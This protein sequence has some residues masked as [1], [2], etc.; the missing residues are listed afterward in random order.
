[1]VDMRDTAVLDKEGDQWTANRLRPNEELETY[2]VNDLLREI[3]DLKIVGVRPKPVGLSERLEALTISRE[4]LLSL[5]TRGYYLT[6]TGQMMSNEGELQ[7]STDEGI[8]YTLRF[9][10]ILHGTGE[11]I[12]AGAETTADQA[13]GPAENRYL[14]VSAVFDPA[15]VTAPPKPANTAFEGKEESA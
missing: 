11:A 4:D 15:S 10:E 2:K 7:V 6:R 12:S 8:V 9:G 3:D 14:L 1:M 5:Q 13:S